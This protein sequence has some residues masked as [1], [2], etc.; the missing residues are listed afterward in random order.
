MGESS[1]QKLEAVVTATE[2]R[3]SERVAAIEARQKKA[4]EVIERQGLDIAR[5]LASL[6]RKLPTAKV[7]GLQTQERS[8][9]ANF[10]TEIAELSAT[11]DEQLNV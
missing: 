4:E 9:D 1:L 7:G 10:R 6:E 11:M 3:I 2:A 8:E 5:D